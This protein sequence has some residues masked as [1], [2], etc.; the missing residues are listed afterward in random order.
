MQMNLGNLLR[1]LYAKLV[2]FIRSLD[3]GTL[4]MTGVLGLALAVIGYVQYKSSTS[5]D[6]GSSSQA[7][8]AGL[9]PPATSQQ[10]PTSFS[11]APLPPHEAQAST[12]EA[13]AVNAALA[14]VR[15]VSISLP[16]VLLNETEIHES[17][18]L[19]S[20]IS[21]IV[22]SLC[23]GRDVYFIV[24][25]ADDVG[26][27]VAADVLEASGFIGTKPDQV[28]AQ[29]VLFCPTPDGRVSEGK[30]SVV[31]QLEP[32]LHIDGH[33]ATM[34]DLKRFISQL[35]L[36]HHPKQGA[37]PLGASPNVAQ[38]PSLSAFFDA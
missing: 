28:A 7:Q 16:G 9:S 19:V 13:R 6:Q 12:P 14:G 4:Q 33:Y 21:P 10:T 24:Q 22:R 27:A 5:R 36:V 38:A 20:D 37:A 34:D 32:D 17:A 11:M 30:V 31:R 3:A 26:Q 8:D 35:W 2:A 29:R 18:S 1:Q 23:Q 15:R 25:V